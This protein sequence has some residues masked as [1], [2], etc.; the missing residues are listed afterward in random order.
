M[1]TRVH[2]KRSMRGVLATASRP[3]LGGLGRMVAAALLL[4]AVAKAGAQA[5]VPDS[6]V[7][8]VCADLRPVLNPPFPVPPNAMFFPEA[9]LRAAQM[10]AAQPQPAQVQRASMIV[11]GPG[12]VPMLRPGFMPV[13]QRSPA[14][15]PAPPRAAPEAR[16][17]EPD[18]RGID[19]WFAEC[20]PGQATGCRILRRAPGPD[21]SPG[22][23]VI[24]AADPRV[25]GR[26]QA[27]V[28]LPL[29]IGVRESIPMLLDDRFIALVPIETCLPAGCI[30][31]VALPPPMVAVLR[32]ANTLKFLAPTPNGQTIP[33]AVPVSGFGDAYQKVA[34]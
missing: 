32:T 16:P 1:T 34:G 28:V 21:G 25:P 26:N 2:A 20:P 30:L 10:Q 24:V 6:C 29:G 3:R 13:Q 31:T 7:G 5:A 17:P 22:V 23:T 27:T 33:F 14:P 11:A 9:Q 19:N 15:A 12:R 8:D 4:G 18:R